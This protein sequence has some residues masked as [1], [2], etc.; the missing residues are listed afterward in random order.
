MG[1]SS[2]HVSHS[3]NFTSANEAENRKVC[4]QGLLQE[5]CWT[6]ALLIFQQHHTCIQTRGASLEIRQ[7]KERPRASEPQDAEMRRA[8]RDC[9]RIQRICCDLQVNGMCN[10]VLSELLL[11]LSQQLPCGFVR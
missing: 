11:H 10:L 9:Y 5:T 6:E 3:W 7:E 1:K 4:S 8:R 2:L